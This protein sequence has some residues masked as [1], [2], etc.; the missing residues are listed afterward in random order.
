MVCDPLAQFYPLPT[1]RS[2]L[3]H[4]GWHQGTFRLRWAHG[5]LLQGRENR[6]AQKRSLRPRKGRGHPLTARSGSLRGSG[7]SEGL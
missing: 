3:V 5:P 6:T 7:E 2:G 1:R 4:G